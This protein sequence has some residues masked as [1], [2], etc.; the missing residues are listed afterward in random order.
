M[1]IIF[2][3]TV[4]IIETLLYSAVEHTFE[5][6]VTLV[7]DIEPGKEKGILLSFSSPFTFF[8]SFCYLCLSFCCSFLSFSLTTF[9][10]QSDAAS[11]YL[12]VRVSDTGEGMNEEQIAALLEPTGIYNLFVLLLFFISCFYFA[13][14]FYLFRNLLY[15]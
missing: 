14:S 15:I 10:E 3:I 1:G 5:G 2:L 13:F 4:Q 7:V 9:S 8:L 12:K 6:G 11:N